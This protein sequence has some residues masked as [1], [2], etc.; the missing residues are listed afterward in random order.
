MSE[1]LA[2]KVL[3]TVPANNSFSEVHKTSVGATAGA[4]VLVYLMAKTE[5]V[6]IFFPHKKRGQRIASLNNQEMGPC[7]G[8]MGI[9]SVK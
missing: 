7:G 9:V 1:A 3:R 8:C 5:S 6:R 2:W 4:S